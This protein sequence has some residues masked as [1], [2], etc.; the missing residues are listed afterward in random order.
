MK[1]QEL[2]YA[3]RVKQIPE[4][5]TRSDKP[6]G[7]GKRVRARKAMDSYGSG[8]CTQGSDTVY[9]YPANTGEVGHRLEVR[10]GVVWQWGEGGA[11]FRVP[12]QVLLGEISCCDG[13]SSKRGK[14]ELEPLDAFYRGW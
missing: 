5:A 3:A 14:Y 11:Y 8:A 12:A 7:N 1:T 4:R 10:E 13:I 2:I 9:L 6:E